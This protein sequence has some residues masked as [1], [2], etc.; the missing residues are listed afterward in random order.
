VRTVIIGAGLSG[1]MAARTLHDAGHEVTVLDKGR[2]VGGRLATRR[3]GEARFD[4]GAQ[5][6]TVR[7]HEFRTVVDQWIAAGVVHEWCRGFAEHDGHPRYVGSSGMT[8]IAKHLAAG[9]DVRTGQLAFTLRHEDGQW[10][11]RT[12]DGIDHAADRVILTAP[13]AQ[14][15]SFLM[16]ID[17]EMPTELRGSDYDRT[18]ALLAVLDSTD[19]GVPSPGGV[20]NPSDDIQFVADNM[21]KGISPIPALTVH[22]SPAFSEEWFDRDIEQSHAE[23][24][25]R[26]APW[27][28]NAGV[29]ASHA[30]KWRFATPRTVHPERCWT[31]PNGEVVMAG[32]AFGGP[33]VE[34]AALSGMAAA[35]AVMSTL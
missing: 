13:V 28:G 32:D 16:N 21:A 3:I 11:V 20:Q 2:G 17:T 18:L 8:G 30:K 23:M 9:L 24:L 6:F 5:F 35:A 1:L 33:K 19:H 7:S 4:H 14:S 29:T 34:G 27:I 25:R 10:Q 31:A 12:D 15:F 26:A 22:F